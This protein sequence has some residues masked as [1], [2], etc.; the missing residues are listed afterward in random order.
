MEQSVARQ[1][2]NLEVVGSS[3]SSATSQS[4]R[5]VF[6]DALFYASRTNRL[7]VTAQAVRYFLPILHFLQSNRNEMY[8]LRG[9]KINDQITVHKFH[10]VREM[11][12]VE[13]ELETEQR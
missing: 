1:A 3:P 12:G 11:I 9:F 5:K 7:N 13:H 6:A 8:L 2:H 10:A 4:V